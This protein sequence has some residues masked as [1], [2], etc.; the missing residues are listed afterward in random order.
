ML[1]KFYQ[2]LFKLLLK[3]VKGKRLGK[4]FPFL[5]KT[6]DT[7]FKI[8][9]PKKPFHHVINNAKFLVDPNEPVKHVRTWMQQYMMYDDYEPETTKLLEK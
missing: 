1:L 7:F 5:W 3:P 8:L 2:E 4:K 6:Y 9:A